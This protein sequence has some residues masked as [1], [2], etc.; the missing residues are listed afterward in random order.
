MNIFNKFNKEKK[1]N[2][3]EDKKQ[4]EI[5]IQDISNDYILTK[6]LTGY[7]TVYDNMYNFGE[8][9]NRISIPVEFN[10]EYISNGRLFCFNEVFE[11]EESLKFKIFKIKVFNIIYYGANTCKTNYMVIEKELDINDLANCIL[12]KYPLIEDIKKQWN[13]KFMNNYEIYF[14]NKY[15]NNL[16]N[17][18]NCDNSFAKMILDEF[19]SINND[20]YKKIYD[21]CNILKN[22]NFTNDKILC[23][24][25]KKRKFI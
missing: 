14:I 22:N 3:K 23:S 16:K 5:I 21:Y 1:E 10:K 6:G 17:I 8:L 18:L 7:I 4:D 25:Y 12:K 13:L 20:S 19:G 9:G 15:I 11:I 24:L 2:G